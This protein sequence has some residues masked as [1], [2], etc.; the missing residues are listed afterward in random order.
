MQPGVLESGTM[1]AAANETL[2][3]SRAQWT[4]AAATWEREG[5]IIAASTRA[6]TEALVEVAGV[7]AGALVLDVAG[8]T[9]DPTMRLAVAVGSS[10]RVV[11]TDLTPA[12][13][14]GARRRI[15]AAGGASVEF[16]V[17]GAETLPFPAAAF[18]TV[19][20]RF[21]VMLFADPA[22]GVGEMLR[23]ARPGGTVAAAVWGAPERNPY[24][25]VPI[26]TVARMASLPPQDPDVPGVF[27]LAAPGA[28]EELFI[29]AGAVDVHGERRAFTM[30]APVRLEEF[31]PFLLRLASPMRATI[32]SL[33]PALQD[34]IAAA[35]RAAVAPYFVDGT[36]RFPAEMIVARATRV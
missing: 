10:G 36:M 21:G 17:A 25:A 1:P 4:V 12:M 28:L 31:W 13:L 34:E 27:R 23:V 7:A 26:A 11:C 5:E 30:E 24:L 8:G 18:D 19:V 6:V 20:S 16:V 2:T 35:V 3:R 32:A 15:A 33:P 29:R 22:A 9:G 14:A